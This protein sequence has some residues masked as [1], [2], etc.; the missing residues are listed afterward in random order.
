MADLVEI[1]R[2][3]RLMRVFPTSQ[4]SRMGPKRRGLKWFKKGESQNHILSPSRDQIT[5]NEVDD[6]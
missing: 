2:R 4:T 1:G 6:L 5:S 3:E